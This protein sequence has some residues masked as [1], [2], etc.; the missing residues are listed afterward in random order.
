MKK[1]KICLFIIMI[2]IGFQT[3]S[4]AK[5]TQVKP[6]GI[7][8]MIV[9][10]NP[11][12]SIEIAEKSMSNNTNLII[13]K[14]D[15]QLQQKFYFDYQEDGYYKIVSLY[16]GKSLTVKDN[17]IEEGSYIVQADYKGLESQ[18][19]ILRDSKIN[20]WVISPLSNKELAISIVTSIKDGAKLKLLKK[21][22]NNMQMF[23]LFNITKEEQKKTNG[24]YKMIVG[25]DTAKTIEVAEGSTAN[26]S[27]LDLGI[28]RRK[29]ISKV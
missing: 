5:E 12:K 14:F 25:A 23:Y 27:N 22:D 6:N 28:Y 4:C 20:G 29:S 13:N 11:S 26:N 15:N 9:G 1:I 24:L 18:K 21:E 10:Q 17:K 2:L 8:K 19:W 7:Y 16:N 3:I